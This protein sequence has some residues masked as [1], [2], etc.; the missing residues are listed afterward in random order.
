MDCA[1]VGASIAEAQY[2]DVARTGRSMPPIVAAPLTL[3]QARL[4]LFGPIVREPI[5]TVSG[6]PFDVKP[7]LNSKRASAAASP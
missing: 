1:I 5:R 7:D 4:S 3:S 6:A 2:L